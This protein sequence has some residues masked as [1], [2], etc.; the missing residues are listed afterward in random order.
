MV[1]A[2]TVQRPGGDAA[3][4]RIHATDKGLAVTTDCT[5]RYC[6]AHPETGGRQAVVEA[7][8]NLTAVGATPLALT[9]NLNFGNPERRPIMGQFVGC[10][11][12]IGA[13]ARALEFPVISGNV[14][15]Y[16]ETNGEA[17][18]PTPVIGGVGLIEDIDATVG[19][20][21]PR[22]ESLD[23]A[24]RRDGR[25]AWKFTL[26][27]GTFQREEGAPP[28]IDLEAER[29]NGNL[30]RSEIQS[31]AIA[32]CHDLSDGGL[33]VGL[34][35]MALAGNCGLTIDYSSDLADHAWYFGEDQA[36]YLCVTKSPDA[37]LT[38]AA[39]ANVSAVVLGVTGGD[40]VESSGW[41]H[42]IS[43]AAYVGYM[44]IGFPTIW[45]ALRKEHSIC[46]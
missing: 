7:W 24:D 30:V 4:V 12:G 15:L 44:K 25:M 1:M 33:L 10:V 34:A 43:S 21:I 8:R 16:N 14:S 36:R 42:H 27:K 40:Y 38:A 11:K 23:C 46:Q 5:P 18:L 20:G 37:L 35:E 31:G 28:P 19:I 26:S 45:L 3:V 41:D 2:D 32:A 9:N 6:K 29:R 13:A 39:K 22:P 17:I